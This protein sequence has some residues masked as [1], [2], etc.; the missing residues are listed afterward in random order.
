MENSFFSSNTEPHVV[1]R[2]VFGGGWTGVVNDRSPFSLCGATYT[3]RNPQTQKTLH[4]AG[5][6]GCYGNGFERSK[7]K[8]N[9]K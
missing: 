6:L 5:W 1:G 4:T 3:T 2:R 9:N 8:N 7:R